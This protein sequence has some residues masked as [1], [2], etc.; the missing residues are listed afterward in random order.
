MTRQYRPRRAPKR[1]LDDDC[2]PEVIAIYDNGDKTFDR[3]TVIYDDVVV[4]GRDTW[5]GYRGMSENPTSPQGFGI[6]DQFREYQLKGFRHRSYRDYAAWSSLPEEVRE[7]VRRDCDSIR[8]DK[9]RAVFAMA[10][11]IAKGGE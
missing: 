6:Y 11:K 8:S 5:I 1:F 2:P 10:E 3:Y 4:D 7:C 9:V